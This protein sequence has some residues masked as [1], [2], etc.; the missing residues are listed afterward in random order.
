[1]SLLNTILNAQG[2]AVVDQLG[3]QFGLGP[4]QAASALSAL[5]PA[6][7]AGVQ[8]NTQTPGGMAGLLSALASGQ[9][10][11]YV[12][13][14]SA[15]ADP[16]TTADGN[17]ILSHLF[18]SKDVSR[19]VAAEAANQTGLGADL[20][21]QM[22]PVAASLVMG[23]MAQ[24]TSSAAVTS[25]TTTPGASVPAA[26]GSTLMSLLNATVTQGSQQGSLAQNVVGMLGGLF[27]R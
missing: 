13:D 14:P 20:L 6:L 12:N 11:K 22:L 16:A 26:G 7:A 10:Q 5:V 25:G 17:G 8:Q 18:G 15:V 24:H 2:G 3:S 27:G 21:K 19:Q 1:M 4:G 9:H 23:A